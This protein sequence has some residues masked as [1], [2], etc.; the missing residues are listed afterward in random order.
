MQAQQAAAHVQYTPHIAN[1]PTEEKTAERRQSSATH[2]ADPQMEDI[3]TGRNLSCIKDS[4]I[5]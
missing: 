5:H 2:D 4:G 3:A 1:K